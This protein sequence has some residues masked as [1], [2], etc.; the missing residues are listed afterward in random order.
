MSNSLF[1]FQ[2]LLSSL[3]LLYLFKNVFSMRGKH[4]YEYFIEHI[5]EKHPCKIGLL[6][7]FLL[8]GPDQE[9]KGVKI[10]NSVLVIKYSS[11]S[12]VII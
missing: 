8:N 10:F 5:L 12:Q 9:V 3:L 6:L 4:S 2:K 1:S 11:F 7:F